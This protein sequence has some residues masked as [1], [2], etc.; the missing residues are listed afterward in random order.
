MRFQVDIII[1]CYQ[2]EYI[3]FSFFFKHREFFIIIFLGITLFRQDVCTYVYFAIELVV[4]QS[5]V[6]SN[7]GI[8]FLM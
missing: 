6:V 7:I 8:T 1:S 5:N 3:S 2:G 4:T